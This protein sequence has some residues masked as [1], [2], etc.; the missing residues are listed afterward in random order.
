MSWEF[1]PALILGGFAAYW[2]VMLA[3]GKGGG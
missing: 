2:V 1:L 3:L